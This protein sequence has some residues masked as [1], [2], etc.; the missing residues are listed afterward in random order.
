[1][2]GAETPFEWSVRVIADAGDASLAEIEDGQG[3]QHVIQLCG[4]EIYVD[5]LAVAYLAGVLK[6]ADS[7]LVENDAGHRQARGRISGGTRRLAR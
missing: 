6:V 5:V 1:V 2:Q 3:L 7:V 4:G